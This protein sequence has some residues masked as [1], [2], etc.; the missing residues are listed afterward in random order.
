MTELLVGQLSDPGPESKLVKR[1]KNALKID[2]SYQRSME[3]SRSR[4]L[5]ERIAANFNWRKF[6]VLVV[7][8]SG[9]IIDGQHRH[10]G[11]MLRPD[12]N[13]VPC[14]V[15]DVDVREAASIFVGMNM[16][17]V[18]IQPQ[19]VYKAELAA[20][21][22]EAI[23]MKAVADEAGVELITNAMAL[24]HLKSNQTQA[25][26]TVRSQ[27]KHNRDACVRALK[28]CVA[29]RVILSSTAI[30]SAF[31]HTV[32]FDDDELTTRMLRQNFV[33]FDGGAVP[34]KNFIPQGTL[35][36]VELER[37]PAPA[38]TGE[39]V[40]GVVVKKFETGSADAILERT[41]RDAG[42]RV[43]IG[44]RGVPQ[45][46]VVTLN[47]SEISYGAAV[48]RANEIRAKKKLPPI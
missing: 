17:R 39:T 29:A 18:N 22:P 42:F 19:A 40:G 35:V 26:S 9:F 14:L 48:E 12:I 25:I 3:S 6:G 16:D 2:P 32:T 11:A 5:V 47:G 38:Q 27:I 28:C 43:W 15:H 44:T 1:H 36:K 33:K 23:T 41:L 45:R 24:R 10:G 4:K 20:G 8:E 34:D 30:Q 46:K 37:A 13:F 31:R 7:T 21:K